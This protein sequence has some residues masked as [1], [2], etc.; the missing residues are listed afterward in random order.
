MSEAARPDA[1]DFRRALALIQHGVR[2]D[3]QGM[4]AIIDDEAAPAGRVHLLA[5]ASVSILWQLAMK[6]RT[7]AQVVRLEELLAS[8][9]ADS[10]K[11]QDNR[12]AYRLALAEWRGQPPGEIDAVLRAATDR[13]GGLIDLALVV[14]RTVVEVLP[15]LRTDDGMQLLNDLAMKARRDEEGGE[16]V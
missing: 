3:E 1:G 15:E 5:R 9:A 11:Q 13:P 8:A 12:L 2:V 4:R 16:D 7:P 6:L 14:A 10:S